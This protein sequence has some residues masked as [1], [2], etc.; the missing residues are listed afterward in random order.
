M[1]M[2]ARPSA[3]S[4]RHRAEPVVAM[5]ASIMATT[6][7]MMKTVETVRSDQPTL[8]RLEQLKINWKTANREA[9]KLRTRKSVILREEE[10]RLATPLRIP[11]RM[12]KMPQ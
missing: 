10:L 12:K 4:G 2:A 9:M 8:T 1:T 7:M 5:T 6:I 11:A 3:A